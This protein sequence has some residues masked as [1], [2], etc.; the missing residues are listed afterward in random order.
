MH[1][2]YT[3]NTAMSY[4]ASVLHYSPFQQKA[5]VN[6]ITFGRHVSIRIYIFGILSS[7]DI[8]WYIYMGPIRG[9]GGSPG[10]VQIFRGGLQK[11]LGQFSE[12]LNISSESSAQA[13]SIGTQME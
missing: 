8:D 1:D 13:Q 5:L 12:I 7:I 11:S 10:G 6:I 2:F 3:G 9:G 4:T